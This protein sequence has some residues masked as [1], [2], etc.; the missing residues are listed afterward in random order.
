MQSSAPLASALFSLQQP[1]QQQKQQ[2]DEQP[3]RRRWVPVSRVELLFVTWGLFVLAAHLSAQA[4]AAQRMTQCYLV[5]HP[6]FTSRPAC[7]VVVINCHR[8]QMNDEH[9]DNDNDNDT[10]ARTTPLLQ[11]L[12][13][14]TLTTLVATHCVAWTMPPVV[15]RFPQLQNIVLYNVTLRA[16]DRAAAV[17]QRRHPALSHVFLGDVR[18]TEF[19]RGLLHEDVPRSLTNVEVSRTNLS[20]L[21]ED[22]GD[23]WKTNEWVRFH[24][25]NSPL[26]RVP[27][28]FWRLGVRRISFINSA[29]ER[30]PDDAIAHASVEI[31]RLTGNPLTALPSL[32]PK[33]LRTLHRLTAERSQLTALPHW[34]EVWWRST[35]ADR[36][37]SFYGTPLCRDNVN[38]ASEM[39]KAV[40]LTTYTDENQGIVPWETMTTLLPVVD[41]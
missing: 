6:W 23:V 38:N 10:V 30:L 3:R 9:N 24:F 32:P 13:G 18:M 15:Q 2:T 25:E 28:S 29:I 16:W 1:Q 39:M 11:A 40:C 19:P 35:P 12:D 14:R 33:D 37:I 31:L 41:G 7:S 20:V 22:M 5:V 4:N 36:K 17:T 27:L 34:I 21:P 8:E 26:T